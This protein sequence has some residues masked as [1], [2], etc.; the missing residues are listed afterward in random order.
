MKLYYMPGACSMS[1][2]IVLREGGFNFELEKV[3]YPTKKTERGADFNKI[4]PKGYVPTLILD[5]GEMLTEGAAI[6]QYLADQKPGS[7]LAPKWG[8]PERYRL[9]EWLS[10]VGA[11]IHKSNGLIFPPNIPEE[12]KNIA[13]KS[14]AVRLAYLD[15][16]LAGKT[17]LMGDAFTVA[18][19]YC[20]WALNAADFLKVDLSP[21]SNVRAYMQ[22]VAARPKVQETLKAEGL[23]G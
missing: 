20:F 10:F 9:Q 6:V 4:N 17:Y 19:A 23:M 13:R 7:G 2:H 18:D 3:D 16:A 11:E 12:T 5:N 1:P 22:R 14:L 21:F 15:A 8:S